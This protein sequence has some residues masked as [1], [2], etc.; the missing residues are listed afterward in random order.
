MPHPIYT[1][2]KNAC[3]LTLGLIAA[4]AHADWALESEASNIQFIT[5]K[6]NAVAEVHSFKQLSGTID[7]SGVAMVEIALD[8]VDTLIPI[9]DERMREHLFQTVEFP[10]AIIGTK[11]DLA[12]LEGLATGSEQLVETTL[13]VSLH[14]AQAKLPTKLRVTALGDGRYLV[15]TAQP[16]LL[17]ASDFDLVAGIEKLREIAGLDSIST[18]VP[19]TVH[20]VWKS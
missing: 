1:S 14:G 3:V 7:K 16:L 18:A 8:S 19:V 17:R 9:R 2:L 4:A 10:T 20:L 13:G 11:V 12:T 6:N 5:T 15:S